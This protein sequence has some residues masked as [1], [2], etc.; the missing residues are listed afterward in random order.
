MNMST[1]LSA[2]ALSVALPCAFSAPDRETVVIDR[3]DGP[4]LAWQA[5]AD[6]GRPPRFSLDHSCLRLDYRDHGQPDW[7]NL[8]LPATLC[9]LEE[10]VCLRLRVEQAEGRAAI[11]IWFFEDDGDCWLSPPISLVPLVGKDWQDIRLPLAQFRHQPRGDGHPDIASTEQLLLGCNWGSFVA[12]VDD[13]V[14]V[15]PKG[16]AE[17]RAQQKHAENQPLTVQNTT[18]IADWFA[19]LAP[20][21]DPLQFMP[22]ST[23]P[24]LARRG[25]NESWWTVERERIRK[26]NLHAIRLWFQIDW[27]EPF[28]DDTDPNQYDP[29][30]RGFAVGSPRM[31]SVYRF[32]DMCQ[33]SD[34]AV[35]LNFGWKLDY[36]A[37]YWLAQPDQMGRSNPNLNSAEEH[38]E[39]LLALLI[40]LRDVRKYTCI[41]HLTLGNEF[42]Y[43]YPDMYPAL[44]KR[45]ETAGLRDQYV[46]EGLE[47]NR[48]VKPCLDWIAQHPGLIDVVTVHTYSHMNLGDVV[49]EAK[50]GTFGHTNRGFYSEFALGPSSIATIGRAVTNAASAGAY[51]TGGWRLGDQHLVSPIE[52]AHGKDRFDHGLHEW[53]TWYWI[54]WMRR[55]RESYFVSALLCRYTQRDSQVFRVDG[56]RKL[57]ATCFAKDGETTLV[58]TN[59]GK[60]EREVNLRFAQ[61]P[62]KPLRRHLCDPAGLPK[63]AYDTIPPGDRVFSDG[64]IQDRLP[65]GAVALYTTLPEW[66]QLE[67]APYVSECQPG[68]TI[69]FSARRI[70]APGNLVWSVDGGGENGTITQGGSYTA[71]AGLPAIDP[72][73]VRATLAD[74]PRAVG[75]AVLSFSGPL[76]SKPPRPIVTTHRDQSGGRGSR[77]YDFGLQAMVGTTLYDSFELSNESDQPVPFTIS[78]T[79]PWLKINPA[80]G[81]LAPGG[82]PVRIEMQIKTVGLTVDRWYRGFVHV[83]TPLGLGHDTLDVFFHTVG[84]NSALVPTP[85]LEQDW[86]DWYQR[87]AA[88]LARNQTVKPDL[89]FIGDS[90]T[91]LFGG[92][93]PD[94]GTGEP[95]WQQFYGQRQ[96]TNMGFGW[97]R[98][99]NVLWRIGHGEL[100][101][102]SPKVIVLN[103]GT[104]NLAS[105]P[106]TRNNTAA[107][108]AEGIG[109]VCD[110]IHAACPNTRILVMGVFPRSEQPTDPVRATIRAINLGLAPLGERPYVKVLDIGDRFLAADGTIPRTLMPDF[111]HPANEG[112]R[113]W[114][115]AIEPTLREWLG[116]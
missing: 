58:L 96:A 64:V 116:E 99:Q 89:V 60:Q 70:A 29:D 109:V 30:F 63:D 47:S 94:R 32:L 101:G 14:L 42:E 102:I 13:L 100:E 112:Y 106:N 6:G 51:A 72:V 83:E 103:I 17:A 59:P 77:S 16:L 31:Q 39:S 91:H 54:P 113:I 7:G 48:G 37:R 5:H 73:I 93:P 36:P 57:L 115:E 88:I 35:Q 8:V 90:I 18:P 79:E 28:N 9:G 15:G 92:E 84:G 10:E 75:L 78:S 85:K 11:H 71:P 104:N 74:D 1:R 2:L 22:E 80:T 40:Y 44:I 55:P 50:L 111:L 41:T 97:D 107:E 86:Y 52:M 108:V 46:I 105:T 43:N 3:F 61:A 33:E 19:T 34:V 110:R 67:V 87:H 25:M 12:Q 23:S 45:L 95:T 4:D 56:A 68:A 76:E 82:E 65:P 98:I 49:A 24:N 53:G 21:Y 27:W 26:M 114:A 69:A 20:Q 62:G 38:A 66:P 81:T